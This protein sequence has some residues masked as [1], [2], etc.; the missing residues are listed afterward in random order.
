VDEEMKSKKQH[1]KDKF[2]GISLGL[3]FNYR[4]SLHRRKWVLYQMSDGLIVERIK[5][6]PNPV[7]YESHA[8]ERLYQINCVNKKVLEEIKQEMELS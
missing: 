8:L 3:E 1:V 7:I 4:L 2:E 5:H 6:E